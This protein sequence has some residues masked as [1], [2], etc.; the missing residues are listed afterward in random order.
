MV[1][2]ALLIGINY[3]N[4]DKYRLSS[5][6]NDVNIIRDFLI[7]YCNYN[8]EDIIV[9]SDSPKEKENASFFNIIKHIKT[10]STQMNESDFLFMYF[11]GHG[12]SVYDGSG[13]ES[14]RKDEMFLPQDWQVSYISDDLLNSL[15]K[16]F[17]CKI[18][19]VFDCCNSG[20]MCDLKYSYNIK[21]NTLIDY[22]N[23]TDDD[24]PEII[25][26]S[27]SGENA[28]SFEKFITKNMINDET[29][30][31]YG[32]FTIFFVHILKSYLEE[33]LSFDNF[34]Y[35]DF[36]NRMNH[37]V[38]PIDVDKEWSVSQLLLHKSIYNTNLKPLVG[39]SFKELKNDI[40]FS[41]RG[42][43]DTKRFFEEGT[44]NRLKK[45]NSS[46][47]SHKVLRQHRKIEFLEK[48]NI[49][50]VEKNN[51]LLSVLNSSA[52]SNNFGMIIR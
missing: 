17:K 13:D 22:L 9:L 49:K 20:T 6:I 36:I 52:L 37:F 44:I 12:G 46:S 21:D 18:A 25:C 40:F 23:N 39:L 10:L 24:I 4:S 16:K 32:E 28:A 3:L 19:T 26:I 8:K 27:S 43:E 5:P 7:N 47:L 41:S 1:H 29:N 45:K 38:T 31:F 42:E 30:K 34:K 11:S 48:K 51:T 15:L 50:L 2:K 33:N 35:S 14:D